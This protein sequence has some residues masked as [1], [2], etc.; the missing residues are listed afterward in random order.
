MG[1]CGVSQTK[2]KYVISDRVR[3]TAKPAQLKAVSEH[4]IT[5][6]TPLVDVK[7]CSQLLSETRG[8]KL[9]PYSI[10]EYC[11]KG[12]WRGKQGTFWVKAGQ[13]YLLNMAAIYDAI[14]K[15]DV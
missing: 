9:S 10:R 15:G 3:S 7:T 4:Q 1:G 2:G 12:K 5:A 8:W 6:D 11:S 14:A 13:Q